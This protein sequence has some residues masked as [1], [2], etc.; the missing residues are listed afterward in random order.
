MLGMRDL[1][2]LIKKA[3]D[4]GLLTATFSHSSISW[5]IWDGGPSTQAN[6]VIPTT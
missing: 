6:P 1:T 2:V 5:K 3:F 4:R